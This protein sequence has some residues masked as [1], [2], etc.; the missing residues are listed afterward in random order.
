DSQGGAFRP[1]YLAAIM[2][3]L[4]VLKVFLQHGADVNRFRTA[5]ATLLHTAANHKDVGVVEALIAAGAD[6]EAEDK[7]GGTPLHQALRSG[8]SEVVQALLKHGA[9]Q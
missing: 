1:L 8:S 5:G 6:L 3:Y 9:D 4:D 2:G 7:D